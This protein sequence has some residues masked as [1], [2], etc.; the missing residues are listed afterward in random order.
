MI[1]RLNLSH[2]VLMDKIKIQVIK[3]GKYFMLLKAANKV[4][5]IFRNINQFKNRSNIT[6]N[7]ISITIALCG[8]LDIQYLAGNIHIITNQSM[9][10]IETAFIIYQ[11]RIL[12]YFFLRLRQIYKTRQ[13]KIQIRKHD[14]VNKLHEYSFM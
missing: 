14:L 1:Q 6:Y 9:C 4:L 5:I 3:K 2:S 12:K 10:Q 7:G 13:W 8:N 11:Q